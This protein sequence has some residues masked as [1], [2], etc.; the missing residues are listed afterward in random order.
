MLLID[1]HFDGAGELVRTYLAPVEIAP[2]A[3]P[4]PAEVPA[5]PAYLALVHEHGP[6][7]R[8]GRVSSQAVVVVMRR[9]GQ[10]LTAGIAIEGPR[11]A[12][13]AGASLAR[14]RW[15][16]QVDA[17]AR[18]YLVLCGAGAEP[19]AALAGGVAAALRHLAFAA[20]DARERG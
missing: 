20:P 4:A 7:R 10:P 15:R 14:L 2:G 5:V 3:E 13:G 18:E 8:Q 1:E 16:A 6:V 12:L 19:L 11:L 9:Y 17:S